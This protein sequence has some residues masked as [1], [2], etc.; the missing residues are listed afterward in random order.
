MFPDIEGSICIA[1]IRLRS[2]IS[3]VADV[4]L[5]QTEDSMK[6]LSTKTV[7]ETVSVTKV[8]HLPWRL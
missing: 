4:M 6:L 2:A 8:T 1:F 3:L 7:T 5:K